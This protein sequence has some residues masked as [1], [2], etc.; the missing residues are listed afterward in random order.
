VEGK[1]WCCLSRRDRQIISLKGKRGGSSFSFAVVMRHFRGWRQLRGER[2]GNGGP[3]IRIYETQ[4]QFMLV[5][6]TS[7]EDLSDRI[8]SKQEVERHIQ[9]CGYLKLSTELSTESYDSKAEAKWQTRLAFARQDAIDRGL[10][11]HL[12]IRDAWE[13]S[14]KG[15]QRF[16]KLDRIFEVANLTSSNLQF[17]QSLFS[18]GWV[19]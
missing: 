17:C 11:K 9:K 18:S 10:L 8:P 14:D 7:L 4:G 5:L 2:K 19:P 12:A 13:I 16:A 15:T 3:S 1:G 6:L